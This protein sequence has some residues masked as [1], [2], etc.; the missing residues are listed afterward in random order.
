MAPAQ[1]TDSGHVL[2]VSDNSI[3]STLLN[4]LGALPETSSRSLRI[5]KSARSIST[6]RRSRTYR[7]VNTDLLVDTGDNNDRQDTTEVRNVPDDEDLSWQ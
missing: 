5:D 6:F 4:P 1:T 2:V 3:G 7:C